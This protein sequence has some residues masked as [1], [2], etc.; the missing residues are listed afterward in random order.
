M[1]RKNDKKVRRKPARAEPF[2]RRFSSR[3]RSRK[4]LWKIK[5][6]DLAMLEDGEDAAGY[7]P[8]NRPPPDNGG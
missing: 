3:Q 1:Q 2:V 6:T 4:P 8:Y 5:V 7:D